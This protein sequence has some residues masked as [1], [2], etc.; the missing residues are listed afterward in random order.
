MEIRKMETITVKK[1]TML[2]AIIG[3]MNAS[4]KNPDL[5]RLSEILFGDLVRDAGYNDVWAFCQAQPFE[6]RLVE[7]V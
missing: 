2:E 1:S 4:Q 5:Y 3:M 6:T 7:E